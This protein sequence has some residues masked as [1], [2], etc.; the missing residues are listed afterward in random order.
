MATCDLCGYPAPCGR[1][2]N[3]WGV[4]EVPSEYEYELG[5]EYWAQAV[6]S[7]FGLKFCE[8]DYCPWP[9]RVPEGE[10]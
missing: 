9:Q 6:L 5:D 8:G 1:C 4:G 10:S 7:G 3:Y 2:E